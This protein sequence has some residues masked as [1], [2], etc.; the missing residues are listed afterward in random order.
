[1]NTDEFSKPGRVVV[2]HGF[3]ITPGLKHGVC[4]DNLVLE[5]GLALLPLAGGADG[6]K[7]GDDLFGVLSLSGSRLSCCDLDLF[8]AKEL[9][10]IDDY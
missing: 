3:G 10:L 1:M 2:S 4:L 6:G 7:V 5:G 8:W 9:W